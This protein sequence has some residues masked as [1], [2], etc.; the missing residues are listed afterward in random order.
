MDIDKQTRCQQSCQSRLLDDFF[1][2]ADT[3]RGGALALTS[4][5]RLCKELGIPIADHK[6]IGPVQIITFLGNELDSNS[7][8]ARLPPEKLDTYRE[9]ILCHV[10]NGKITLRQLKSIIGKLQFATTVVQPGRAFLRRLCDLAMQVNKQH[11][12]TR[13]T[14]S[15]K[16]DLDTWYHFLQNYN[17]ITIIRQPSRVDSHSLQTRITIDLLPSRIFCPKCWKK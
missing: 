9:E 16:Q 8:I 14:Q 12:Y 7:M 2:V 13:L 17:G 4:F 15:A 1:F 3:E 11:Y 6:T 10:T 5:R